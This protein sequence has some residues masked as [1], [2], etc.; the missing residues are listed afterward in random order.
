M[1]RANEQPIEHSPLPS[2]QNG[3]REVVASDSFPKPFA[4]NQPPRTLC[5]EVPVVPHIS[6]VLRDMRPQ[7]A[8]LRAERV[9]TCSVGYVSC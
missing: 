2:N 1:V 7:V 8:Q 3:P 9:V 5:L 6:T 4:Q